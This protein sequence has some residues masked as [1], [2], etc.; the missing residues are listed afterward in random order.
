MRLEKVQIEMNSYMGCAVI[1]RE[2]K[3]RIRDTKRVA[4]K[5][6]CLCLYN[7]GGHFEQLIAEVLTYTP[8]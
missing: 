6:A 3:K 7:A 4:L 1:I 2:D 5:R 8:T